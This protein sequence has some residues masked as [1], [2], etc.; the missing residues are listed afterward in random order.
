MSSDTVPDAS[1]SKAQ[2][3]ADAPGRRWRGRNVVRPQDTT[4]RITVLGQAL[5]VMQSPEIMAFIDRRVAMRSRTIIANHNLHSIYLIEREP[6]MAALYDQA[7][8]IQ[9]DSVPLIKFARMTG[10]SVGL[11]HRST[12]LDWRDDFWT[13]AHNRCWRIFYLGSADGV[14]MSATRRLAM[15]YPDIS[16]AARDGYF[17]AEQGSAENEAVLR[18]IRQFAPDVLLVGMG[19]PRQEIWIAES[20]RD[21]PPCVILP[22]GA[23][24]DYE[25]GV[26]DAAPRWMGRW[27]IE[28]LFRL[29]RD[30]KRLAGRYLYEPWFLLKP[31]LRDIF[32]RQ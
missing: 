4:R 9:I 13:M 24:F 21:L 3:A 27:G 26:Q 2:D 31:A 32:K 1:R 16:F 20:L 28:W 6:R 25:A 30:P 8:I 19:M 14:A 29:S 15:T 11:E 7:D 18:Q 10:H 23:A 12:Y 5:D 22:V 17:A